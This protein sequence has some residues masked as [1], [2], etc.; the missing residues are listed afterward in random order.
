LAAVATIPSVSL[1]L[2]MA[3]LSSILLEVFL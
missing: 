1:L 2:S 3:G